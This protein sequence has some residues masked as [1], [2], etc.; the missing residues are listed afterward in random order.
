MDNPPK[1]DVYCSADTAEAAIQHRGATL[2]IRFA[3]DDQAGRGLPVSFEICPGSEPLEPRVLRR[4]APQAELYVAYARSALR[5]FG[6][7]RF[8]GEE[9]S[10]ERLE[11]L[12]DA[13]QPLR[14]VGRAGRGLSPRFYETIADQYRLL[15]EEGERHPVKALGEMHGATISAASRWVKEARRRDLLPPKERRQS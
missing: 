3:G 12:A 15:V 14:Q 9:T 13:T 5:T 2:R 7:A 1:V 11:A 10:E 6:L 4:F 8:A